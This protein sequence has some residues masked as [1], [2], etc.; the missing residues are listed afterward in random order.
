MRWFRT[1]ELILGVFLT[2]AVF[3]MGFVVASSIH[4]QQEEQQQRTTQSTAQIGNK[5]SADERVADYTLAVAW[6]TGVLAFSTIGLWF[7]TRRS[8]K[9][10]E[11]ALTELEAPFIIVKIKDPGIHCG[12]TRKITFS[13]LKYCFANYGRTPAHILEFSDIITEANVDEGLPTPID[14]IKEP[15]TPMPY[16]V[17]STPDGTAQDFNVLTNNLNFFEG[18]PYETPREITK[19]AFFR[20]FVRYGDIFGNEFVLGFCF[21]FD[22]HNNRW[23]LRG[24]ENH[25]YCRKEKGRPKSPDWYQPSADPQSIAAAIFRASKRVEANS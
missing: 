3:A 21:L 1:H 19:K 6:L 8:A 13:E 23:V 7:V 16:G 22:I 14:P 4:P 18:A 2:I 11:R 12:P 25:N 24:N 9:I 20:G 17:I 5:S 15:G 10:A